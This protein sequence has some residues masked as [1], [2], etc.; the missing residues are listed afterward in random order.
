MNQ[1]NRS[2]GSPARLLSNRDEL[3]PIRIDEHPQVG[4]ATKDCTS[5]LANESHQ[6]P[7]TSTKGSASNPVLAATTVT[8]HHDRMIR[9]AR[10]WVFMALA[11]CILGSCSAHGGRPDGSAKCVTT[12]SA[13]VCGAID[14]GRLVMTADGLQ[15]GSVL[16][17]DVEG[18]GPAEWTVSDSGDLIN[19]PGELGFL[20]YSGQFGTISIEATGADGDLVAGEI[21]LD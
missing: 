18:L 15:A 8:G 11:T 3:L 16:R 7:I 19:P 21:L 20:I 10:V 14:G 6:Q 17:I 13:Q 4:L 5:P 9:T 2:D 12:D 1:P